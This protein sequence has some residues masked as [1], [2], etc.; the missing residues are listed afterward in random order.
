MLFHRSTTIILLVIATALGN[1]QAETL[2]GF[3]SDTL[4]KEGSDLK[5]KF[6]AWAKEHEKTYE[7]IKEAAE[8]F[9]IW[10]ENHFLIEEHNDKEPTPS[11]LLGHNQFSDMTNEEFQRYNKL[12]EYSSGVMT[13]NGIHQDLESET[14]RILMVE[15]ESEEGND[16]TVPDLVD[17]VEAGAVTEIKNQGAC[18]SC[19]A[20]SA[21]GSL[22]SAY[23]LKSGDLVSLSPQQLV[24]CDKKDL[25]CNGGLMDSAFVYDE[26]AGGLCK[27]EDYP[28]VAKKEVCDIECTEVEGSAA[29]SYVDVKPSPDALMAAIAIQPVSVAIQ[30]NQMKFQLYKSGVFDEYCFQHVDH[31]VVAVGYGTD[32]ESRLDYWK[33]KNSWGE[34]W[35]D[36]G[37]IR[38]AR[39]SLSKKG[40]CGILTAASYPVV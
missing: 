25:G 23:F 26:L 30:A 36:K 15:E 31:G 28:Y 39:S 12:G 16:V 6:G 4:S 10:M 11:F 22:E 7:S 24:D 19:W 8:R 14:S 20:F 38:I 40:R 1:A 5:E 27:F 32:E 13:P 37:Y 2:R 33:I 9:E 34:K 18:G 35:G 3:P 17:W 29:K 21:A